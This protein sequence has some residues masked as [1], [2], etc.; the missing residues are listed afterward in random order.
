MGVKIIAIIF[1][2]SIVFCQSEDLVDDRLSWLLTNPDNI[3][4]LDEDKSKNMQKMWGICTKS[5]DIGTTMKYWVYMKVW[6][7]LIV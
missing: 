1:S 4:K 5:F 2:I 6:K 7:E 3:D